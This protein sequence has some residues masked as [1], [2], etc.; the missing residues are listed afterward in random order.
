MKKN[1]VFFAFFVISFSQIQA[2]DYL[3]QWRNSDT[4]ELIEIIS[5]TIYHYEINDNCYNLEKFVY[6]DSGNNTLILSVAGQSQNINYTL[7]NANT[8]LNM[9]SI[10]DSIT[11]YSYTFNISDYEP[12]SGSSSNDYIGQWTTNDPMLMYVE[13]TA[14]S[15]YNYQFE[16]D[17]GGCYITNSMH[18]YDNGNNQLILA[19][20]VISDYSLSD[21]EEELTFFIPALDDVTFQRTTF[22]TVGWVECTFNWKC[23]A[24]TGNCQEVDDFSGDYTNEQH[25]IA[26]CQADTSSSDSSSSVHEFYM[27]IAI[28]PN[29]F[30]H[31]TTLEFKEKVNYYQLFDVFGRLIFSKSVDN[32]IDYFHRG[33]LS[34]GVYFLQFVGDQKISRR[35]VVIE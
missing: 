31:S 25:C 20:F 1:A 26:N 7:Q 16:Y 2:Q 9:M 19:N 24:E 22:D 6:S 29:P 5:D 17:T 11:Y 23:I 10:Y 33:N 30:T 3:G 12:C 8:V 13:F 27:D 15:L 28:Y 21:D 4:T 18:Y 32:T 34:R 14:D 35:R